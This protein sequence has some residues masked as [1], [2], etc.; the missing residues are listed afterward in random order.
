M[1]LTVITESAASAIG[2]AAAPLAF[3]LLSW[4]IVAAMVDRERLVTGRRA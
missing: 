3:D 1:S 2:L 4:R